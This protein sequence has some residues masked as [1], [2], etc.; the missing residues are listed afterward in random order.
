MELA[1][2]TPVIYKGKPHMYLGASRFIKGRH[3]VARQDK[4][5]VVLTAIKTSEFT[6]TTPVFFDFNL[7]P[8][9]EAKL[10]KF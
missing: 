6:V 10:A 3:M 9:Q 2:G 7:T 8:E 4:G 5:N 1:R